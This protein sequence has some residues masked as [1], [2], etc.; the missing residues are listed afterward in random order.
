MH[1]TVEQVALRKN[2]ANHSLDREQYN[3]QVGNFRLLYYVYRK[4]A[5]VVKKNCEI[6]TRSTM[7]DKEVF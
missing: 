6:V 4:S 1:I 3:F 5:S 7:R 2:M